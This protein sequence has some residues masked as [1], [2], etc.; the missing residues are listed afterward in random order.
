MGENTSTSSRSADITVSCT[1][2]GKTGSNSFTITQAAGVRYQFTIK[3]NSTYQLYGKFGSITPPGQE[4]AVDLPPGEKQTVYIASDTVTIKNFIGQVQGKTSGT[5][6]FTCSGA[7]EGTMSGNIQ[8]SGGFDNVINI[9]D[10]LTVKNGTTITI[11][12][13]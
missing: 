6:K 5:V 11:T 10:S 7:S 3:N 9:T 8:S 12:I 1:A 13:S 4:V 2:N